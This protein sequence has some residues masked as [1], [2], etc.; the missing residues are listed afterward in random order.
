MHSIFRNVFQRKTRTSLEEKQQDGKEK[1]AMSAQTQA[2]I[3]K[4]FTLFS[5]RQCKSILH[6][7]ESGKG[8]TFLKWQEPNSV[9]SQIG[10]VLMYVIL[11]FSSLCI[12]SRH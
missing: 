12:I 4:L 6:Y 2:Q 11:L 3:L 8:I 1:Q 7:W 9:L 10:E 5:L